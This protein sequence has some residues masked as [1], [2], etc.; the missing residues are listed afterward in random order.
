MAA[1]GGK[2]KRELAHKLSFRLMLDFFSAQ[3][4]LGYGTVM[5]E[6][7]WEEHEQLRGGR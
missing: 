4:L 6:G 1:R 3:S 7:A 5:A 2:G